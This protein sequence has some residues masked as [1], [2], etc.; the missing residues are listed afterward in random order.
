MSGPP[1]ADALAVVDEFGRAIRA[2]T[3]S[4]MFR[5]HVAAAGLRPIRLHDMRHTAASRLISMGLDPVSAAAWLGHTP[6]M[7][8]DVY[9]HPYTATMVAAGRM[10]AGSGAPAMASGEA[11]GT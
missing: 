8:L 5:S 6:T 2:E 7:T 3:F 11:V 4:R 1:P 10:L 9:S